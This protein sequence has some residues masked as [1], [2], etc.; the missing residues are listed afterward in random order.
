MKDAMDLK[1]PDRVPLM[2]QLSIG[3]MLRQLGVSPLE[4]WHDMKAFS[5]GLVTLREIYEFDGVL[6]SLHGHDPAWKDKMV[7]RSVNAGMEEVVWQNGEAFRYVKD[8]LPQPLN[9]EAER[10]LL[11]E[12]N[13]DELP[14]ELTYI[15]VS[16][17][18][19]FPI[20][21]GNRFDIFREIRSKVGDEFSVHGEI[22][23]PFDYFLDMFGYQEALLYLLTE[24][25]KSRSF[26]GHFASMVK[27]LAVDMCDEDVDA[28]KISSPFAG[29]GFISKDAYRQFVLP[30]ESEIAQT[31]RSKG[32]HVYTH[33]CGAVSDRLEMMFDSGVSGIEC[34]DPPPLGDVELED[35]KRRT[36][37]RGFIKGNIDSVNTLL[38]GKPEQ[39]LADA[40]HRLVV[41]KEEGGFILST[42]CSV[43]PGVDRS[44]LLLLREAIDTWG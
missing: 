2:C 26:L 19:R 20:T 5:E 38:Y 35:A 4:F 12:L 10:P 40:R 25:A 32:V 24:P 42:A 8:D 41:G 1:S 18:L 6:V 27:K 43:A 9:P 3:H 11:E 33:T 31:V 30:F 13:V 44:K 39:I 23:S 16:K 36:K 21:A 14:S 28:I 34:L 22:T 37:G 15:P 7:S 29:S 17:G